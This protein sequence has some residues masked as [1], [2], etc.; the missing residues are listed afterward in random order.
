MLQ[1]NRIDLIAFDERSFLR[2]LRIENHNPTEFES[3]FLLTEEKDYYAFHKD[4]PDSL[5][6]R[7]QEALNSL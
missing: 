4:T 2:L 1:L 5:I 3:V 6:H 7:F